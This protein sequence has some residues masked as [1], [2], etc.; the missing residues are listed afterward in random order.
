MPGSLLTAPALFLA[1]MGASV[2][3]SLMCGALSVHHARASARLPLPYQLALTQ[4]GRVL[5]Y[6][7]LGA[8]AGGAGQ[9]VLRHLPALAL[10]RTLQ[11]LAALGLI[12]VGAQLAWSRPPAPACCRAPEPQGLRRWPSGAQAFSRGLLWAAVPCGLLYSVL[13]LAA[14][15]GNAGSGA[16][17]SGAF[18]LGGSPLLAAV[19]WSGARRTLPARRLRGTGWGLMGLGA[20]GLAAIVL[21]HAGGPAWC[22]LP[23]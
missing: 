22:S 2:H 11:A 3:C 16:L 5:G 10:G 20:A 19:G 12:V 8:L 23:A 13:A 1:G 9:A 14:V 6:G 21:L 18:A 15:S 4:A 7:A 17:L